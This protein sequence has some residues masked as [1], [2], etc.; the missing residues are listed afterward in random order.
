VFSCALPPAIAAGLR[1]SLEIARAEPQLRERLWENVRVLQAALRARSVDIGDS[2][3]QVVPIMIR[4]DDKIFAIGEDL[5]RA[6]VYLHPIRY[7]AV[8][9]HR[10]RFRISVSAA[11]TT[12]QLERG[13]EIIATVLREHGICR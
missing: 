13:A 6:G 12:E 7:P 1:K 5:L 9:K 8:G 4:D 10:S 2:V 3:S 11:H